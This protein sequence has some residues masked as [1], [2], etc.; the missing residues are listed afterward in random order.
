[1]SREAISTRLVRRTT[2]VR[3]LRALVAV[4]ALAST[5]CAAGE[6]TLINP[7]LEGA[8]EVTVETSG[9]MKDTSYELLVDGL[10]EGTLAADDAVV[11]AELEP[12]TYQLALADVAANCTAD[13]QSVSVASEQTA[14]GLLTVVCVAGAASPYTIRYSRARPNLDD[15]SITECPFS[16]CPTEEGWDFY[17]EYD[18]GSDPNSILRANETT[19]V[20]IA[21]VAGVTLGSLTEADVTGATFTIEPIDDPFDAGR[22]I[23]VRT[24]VGDIYALGNP[25][26]N[27]TFQTLTFDAVLVVPAS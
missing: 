25:E 7:V 6:D 24:D 21:H 16:L 5:A 20:E 14:S 26:E 1:M 27:N 2:G 17:I 12:A 11:L 8:I 18:A 15:G 23:L 22:V 3:D 10:S 13:N 19:G 4:I 9:F